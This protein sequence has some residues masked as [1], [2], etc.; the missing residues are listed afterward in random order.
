MLSLPPMLMITWRI[1]SESLLYDSIAFVACSNTSFWFCSAYISI[2]L[3]HSSALLSSW[4]ITSY[5]SSC[6]LQQQCWCFSPWCGPAHSSW[7]S[8]SFLLWHH[9]RPQD[10]WMCSSS[11][12]GTISLSDW[13]E[14]MPISAALW[15]ACQLCDFHSLSVKILEY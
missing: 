15:I 4:K 1:H 13:W 9:F 6:S 2:L 11:L 3:L 5:F 12:S 14:H 7:S 8:L 10:T